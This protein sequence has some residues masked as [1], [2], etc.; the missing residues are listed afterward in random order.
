MVGSCQHTNGLSHIPQN[1]GNFLI[2]KELLAP[3]EGPYSMESVVGE[4]MT[5]D[6]LYSPEYKNSLRKTNP[7]HLI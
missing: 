2:A 1:A 3:H 7:T 4:I 6:L 5:E